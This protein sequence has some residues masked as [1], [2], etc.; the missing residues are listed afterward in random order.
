M[1]KVQ[2]LSNSQ[3]LPQ[4][5]LNQEPGSSSPNSPLKHDICIQFDR[6]L[7]INP[8]FTKDSIMPGDF[9]LVDDSKQK[10]KF[11]DFLQESNID[12][13]SISDD[14]EDLLICKQSCQ[15]YPFFVQLFDMLIPQYD[16]K[17]LAQ[18]CQ[19][20]DFKLIFSEVIEKFPFNFENQFEYILKCLSFPD[21][22]TVNQIQ[23]KQFYYFLKILHHLGT[24]FRQ[25]IVLF[26]KDK[27]HIS[28][29]H[30][31]SFNCL[32]V[33]IHIVD[34]GQDGYEF[35]FSLKP[36]KP[37]KLKQNQGDED[38]DSKCFMYGSPEP[39]LIDSYYQDSNGSKKRFYKLLSSNQPSNSF[40]LPFYPKRNNS[41]FYIGCYDTETILDIFHNNSTMYVIALNGS[42]ISI[43]EGEIGSQKLDDMHTSYRIE[44]NDNTR[45]RTAKFIIDGQSL[46]CAVITQTTGDGQ[47]KGFTIDFYVKQLSHQLTKI[48]PSIQLCSR[49]KSPINF[50]EIWIKKSS[51]TFT[52]AFDYKVIDFRL[53]AP[54]KGDA[55]YG[56]LFSDNQYNYYIS[57]V[58]KFGSDQKLVPTKIDVQQQPILGIKNNELTYINNDF[59]VTAGPLDDFSQF[60][61]IIGVE[62]NNNLFIRI[63]HEKNNNDYDNDD[64]ILSNSIEYFHPPRIH[65]QLRYAI[66]SLFDRY[67]EKVDQV[68]LFKNPRHLGIIKGFVNVGFNFKTQ[69]IFKSSELIPGI[70]YEIKKEVVEYSNRTFETK[71]ILSLFFENSGLLVG[72]NEHRTKCQI[73]ALY[74]CATVFYVYGPGTKITKY[75]PKN[76]A[77]DNWV[78]ENQPLDVPN[79]MLSSLL[80]TYGVLLQMKDDYEFDFALRVLTI[81]ERMADD[82][83]AFYQNEFVAKLWDIE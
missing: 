37:E 50:S 21:P 19:S 51:R 76:E 24:Y 9:D 40:L 30:I 81:T 54:Y 36:E 53:F 20:N 2:V 34:Q 46:T 60:N 73:A 56:F 47:G 45:I 4:E 75:S 74:S 65:H 55:K 66:L 61:S 59:N 77:Y 71:S 72:K 27:D 15:V 12:A 18:I 43:F 5:L 41:L 80:S 22:E 8:C 63:E 78:C 39:S 58:T 52:F 3:F 26:N 62:I 68:H 83:Y 33:F 31:A 69:P 10:L 6:E 32:F 38:S 17:V 29:G 16:P 7:D 14:F 23:F 44:E 11:P 28:L 82:F 48:S 64:K 67:K 49:P 70:Y 57:T 25:R 1:A 79:L 13:F 42:Q 35:S